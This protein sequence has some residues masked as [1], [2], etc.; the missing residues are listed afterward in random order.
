MKVKDYPV[1]YKS[2]LYTCCEQHVSECDDEC[3]IGDVIECEYCS[4]KM[5]LENRDGKIMWRAV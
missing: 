4:I 2:H 5:K 1:D 3:K